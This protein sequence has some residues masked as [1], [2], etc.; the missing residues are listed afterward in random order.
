MRAVRC[1]LHMHSCLSP[2]SDADMTPNNIVNMALLN[3]MDMIALT[4]HNSCLNCPAVMEAAQG[5]G[6]CVVPGMELCTAEEA[7][8]VCLFSTLENALSFSEDIRRRLPPV[9]NRPEIFGEQVILNA[10]DERVGTEE[11]LLV[12]ASSVS[13]DEVVALAARCGG[14]AFPAHVD[15]P[16]Y[17]VTA[18]LGDIP[19]D[20]GFTC[21]EVSRT[22][23]V[24]AMKKKYPILEQLFVLRNSDAHALGNMTEEGNL[25]LLDELSPACL[26]KAIREGT[27]QRA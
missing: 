21:A 14:C 4:D 16:S 12:T 17:S 20:A 3:G 22:G 5:T 18:A 10:Q 19:P 13:A 11:L 27:L 1:D 25:L 6:L 2:C 7:H 9:K 23:D 15:R 8:V 26:V 24:E